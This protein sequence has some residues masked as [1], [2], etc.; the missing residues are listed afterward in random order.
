M[1]L[2]PLLA[3]ASPIPS[4]AFA[5]LAAAALGGAQLLRPKGGRG[6]RWIGW[7]FVALM[8]WTA[9]SAL[10]ISSIRVWGPFSPIHLLIP[11]TLGA[12]VYAVRAARRGNLRAHRWTMLS[13][14]ALALVLTGAFT[15]LPGRVMHAVLFGE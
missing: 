5:A 9:L 2:D 14:Y 1:T 11:T 3:A 13:L 10:F 15:L 7:A 6:H 12:L 4:H 8:A